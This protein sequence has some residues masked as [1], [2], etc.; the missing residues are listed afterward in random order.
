MSKEVFVDF[1]GTMKLDGKTK[2]T[3]VGLG[4]GLEETITAEQ[5]AELAPEIRQ[6]YILTSFNDAGRMAD[7]FDVNQMFFRIESN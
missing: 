4:Q 3:L 5:W 2:F 6:Q 1:A 7:E